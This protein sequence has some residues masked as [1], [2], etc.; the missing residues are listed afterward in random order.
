M[1][2]LAMANIYIVSTKCIS[3]VVILFIRIVN[4]LIVLFFLLEKICIQLKECF[5]INIL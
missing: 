5:L 3:T 4:N 1:A 2:Y